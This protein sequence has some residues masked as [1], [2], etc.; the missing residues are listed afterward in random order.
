MSGASRERPYKGKKHDFGGKKG[1]KVTQDR[2]WGTGQRQRG[3]DAWD[4]TK[5]EKVFSREGKSQYGGSH[6]N[7]RRK[8][9][10]GTEKKKKICASK[11]KKRGGGGGNST[12]AASRRKRKKWSGWSGGEKKKAP[13]VNQV[14]P[15][16]VPP[17]G[18][19]GGGVWWGGRG[20]GGPVC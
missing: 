2:S 15:G 13:G 4:D 10:H 7:A 8:N 6:A 18:G 11:K 20:G 19:G 3:G 12:G 9:C 5:W 14:G 17:K 1:T 16:P